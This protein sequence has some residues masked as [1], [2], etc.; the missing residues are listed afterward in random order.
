LTAY[1]IWGL[2]RLGLVWN[3]YRI[4]PANIQARLAKDRKPD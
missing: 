3:V 1:L 4:A 2:E